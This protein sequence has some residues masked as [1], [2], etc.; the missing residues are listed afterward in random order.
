MIRIAARAPVLAI[1]V[2]LVI[3]IIPYMPVYAQPSPLVAV[4]VECHGLTIAGGDFDD[5][6]E[7]GVKVDGIVYENG[8]T[9]TINGKTYTVLIGSSTTTINGTPNNDFIV[10]TNNNDTIYGGAGDDFIV[11][12]DGN[13][14]IYGDYLHDTDGN[15]TIIGGDDIICGNGG[16][17]WLYGDGIFGD[18]GNDILQ[19][20]NDILYGGD[21]NDE[22]VGDNIEGGDGNNKMIGGHDILNGGEGWDRLSGDIIVGYITHPKDNYRYPELEVYPL[23]NDI[24]QG[25]NDTLEGGDGN[26]GLFGDNILADNTDAV[27]GGND[28]IIA[29]DGASDN[30]MGDNISGIPIRGIHDVCIVDDRHTYTYDVIDDI[31]DNVAECEHNDILTFEA[32][33]PTINIGQ[34][35]NLVFTYHVNDNVKITSITVTTPNND[36]CTYNGTLPVIVQPYTS[37][38]AMYPTNFTGDNCNTNTAGTYTAT[39]YREVGNP[40]VTTFNISFNVVP[41]IVGMVGVIGSIFIGLMF[42]MRRVRRSK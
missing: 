29:R 37:F 40:I 17:D 33:S 16:N 32:S 22:L 36:T 27:T 9:I 19:G 13:D 24:L 10:G 35:V 41:E 14:W 23:G 12:L 2:V 21:G 5:D 28:I 38:T 26:D 30:V 4:E 6:G 7:D 42:Y 18:A 39:L 3:G 25:G 11:G 31:H 20:G 15:D 34:S 1:A 8:A